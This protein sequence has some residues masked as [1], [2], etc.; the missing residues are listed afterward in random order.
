MIRVH[1]KV[2]VDRKI[3]NAVDAP[4]GVI[5]GNSLIDRPACDACSRQHTYIGN[6]YVAAAKELHSNS[7]ITVRVSEWASCSAFN[8]SLNLSPRAFIASPFSYSCHEATSHGCTNGW[9]WISI[10]IHVQ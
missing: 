2:E 7:K 4:T 10:I 3:D 5:G 6:K 1:T 8:N 9:R